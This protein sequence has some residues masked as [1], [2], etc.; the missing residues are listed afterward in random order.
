MSNTS[1]TLNAIHDFVTR[2]FP[3]ES[4][5][6]TVTEMVAA[7]K[8]QYN[9]DGDLRINVSQFRS[10]IRALRRRKSEFAKAET[11]EEIPCPDATRYPP[12]S[13]RLILRTVIRGRLPKNLSQSEPNA[14]AGRT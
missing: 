13:C 12:A 2:M 10:A 3:D 4:G 6:W 8:L 7:T 9:A 5:Q 1:P 14:H 11:I